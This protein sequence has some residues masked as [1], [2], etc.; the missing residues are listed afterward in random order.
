MNPADIIQND[1]IGAALISQSVQGFCEND[2]SGMPLI[3]SCCILPLVFHRQSCRQINGRRGDGAFYRLVEETPRIAAGLEARAKLMMPQTLDALN[4]GMTSGIIRIQ[5]E[6]CCLLADSFKIPVK[7]SN[8][9]VSQKMRAA[10]KLG[11]WFAVVGVAQV[12]AW[13]NLRM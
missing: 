7:F 8:N 5:P 13:L 11:N 3:L 2:K 9:E 12:C 6:S 10:N 4:L 1:A